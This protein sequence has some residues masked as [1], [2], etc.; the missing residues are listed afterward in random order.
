MW[1]DGEGRGEGREGTRC[2]SQESKGT[3][4]VGNQIRRT[5]QVSVMESS[6]NGMGYASQEGSVTDR[7]QGMPREPGSQCPL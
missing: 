3:K 6:G 2:S 4:R 7:D 1:G 5:A